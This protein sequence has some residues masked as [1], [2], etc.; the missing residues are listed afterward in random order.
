MSQNLFFA[1]ILDLTKTNYLKT[2]K[3]KNKN[4][5]L[6]WSARVNIIVLEQY[7]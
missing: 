2:G 7:F 6:S 3:L 1:G 4:Q 5:Y